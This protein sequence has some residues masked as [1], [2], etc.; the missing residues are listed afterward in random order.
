MSDYI[1]AT[2]F[3]AKDALLTGNPDKIIKGAEIDA[4]YNAI[5]VAVATKASLN[6]PNFTGT[7][8]VPTASSVTNSTQVASTAFVQNIA[9][10]LGTMST[11]DA[12]TVAITGGSI[13]GITDLAVADGGTGASTLTG[14]V[15]GNG[16]SAMT[17]VAPGTSGNILASNGTAWQSV[18]PTAIPD[19]PSL[20]VGQTW[21][22]LS[23]SRSLATTYT[24]STGKPIQIYV[25]VTST[26]AETANIPSGAILRATING[27]TFADVGIS[28]AST[29]GTAHPTFSLVIPNGDTYRF[30]VI[31]TSSSALV[32]W[33]LR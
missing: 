1:K 10:T 18:A 26:L 13:A 30:T 9:S 16:T 14:V 5:A 31:S 12:D 8:T 25:K 3:F 33:E 15:I 19:T 29:S 17:A 23:E 22:N 2:N 27:E 4:E 24:N 28:L 7:P 11:Q 20:G 32:W 6:S 21:Q